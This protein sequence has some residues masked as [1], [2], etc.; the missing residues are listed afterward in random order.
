M[1]SR[2]SLGQAYTAA[3]GLFGAASL[4]AAG[5]CDIYQSGGTPCVAAHS[6]TRALY[7]AFNG[8]L[9]QVTRD[10]DGAKTDVKTLSAGGVA[11]AA[12]QDSFC[13]GTTCLIS[14]IYDQSERKNHLTRAP[15]GGFKGPEADG[16]D[17]LASATGAPVTLNGRKAYGVFVS[18]GTGYRNNRPSGIAVG[19]QAEGMYAVFDGTHYNSGCCFDYGNAE[20][21]S[22]DT[23]NGHMEAL[24]FGD[25]TYW[26]SGAG[27]GPWLMADLENGLFSGRGSK[28]NPGDPSIS[29]RFFTAI[30]KGRPNEWA[31]RGGNSA[32]GSLS[33]YYSGARPSAAGYNPMSKEGAIILGIGGDNSISAQGT[34][35]EGVMT[36][37]Y[38]SDATEN[39]VQADIVAAKYATTSLTS[40]SGLTV[41]S[42]VSLRATTSG[43]DT[44]Y[45]AHDGATVNTQVVSS[46]SSAALKKQASWTVRPGLSND[47]CFSFESRD[48]PGRYI[49]HYDFAL[50][51]QASDNSRQ[52][53]EDATFCPQE[54][55]NGQGHSIRSWGYPTRYFRH[56]SN[57]AYTASN[58]GIHTFDAA[59]SFNDDVSWVIS[60]GFD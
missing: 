41:G 45:L 18:P 1:F 19:D 24:Y 35:Y 33:T 46:S 29:A 31:I 47:G 25:S 15:P 21:N 22:L 53:K 37:G 58:G 11:N 4:V 28:N 16:S 7:S 48:T 14:I 43:Y 5:P 59:K 9:Y 10:S 54:G 55:L 3:W 8:A 57:V 34:F 6:T 36:S 20:T 52:F 32:S 51:L 40:G 49:R 17:N 56:Y 60:A 12:A 39:A 26:G 30:L 50:Q 23:G 27:K 42:S 2:P 13:A 38:P 44:R